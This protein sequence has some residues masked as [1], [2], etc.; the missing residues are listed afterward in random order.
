MTTS[1]APPVGRAGRNLP[2]AI[3]VG[4]GLGAL[5]LG[6]LYSPARWTF[7]VVIAAASVVGTL[8]V[9]RALRQLGAQPPVVPVL[10][11]GTAMV[12]A[13]YRYGAEEVFLALTLTSLAC[14]LWRLAEP[15]A[16]L[17]R[18]VTAGVLTT[19]YVPF[20]VSFAAMLTV[21]GDGPRRITA[22]IATVVCSDVGGYAAGVLLGKHPM[23]PTVSP[24]KSWEGFAGSVLACATAGGVFFATLFAGTHWWEGVLFGLA[25]VCSATLGDLG[26]SMIKRD[27]GIKDM[28]HLLPGHGGLMDRLDSLLPTAPVAWLLLTAF[29]PLP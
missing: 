21:P 27:I 6:T 12:L 5:V 13:G 2:A 17:L 4:L 25:V 15:A 7:V 19:A 10:V 22:F 9:V 29:V 11:G 1:D 20:L 26:E 8:E 16:G 14:V 23:A 3:G 28:G 18:D 24:K